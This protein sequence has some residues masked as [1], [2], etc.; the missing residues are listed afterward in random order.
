MSYLKRPDLAGLLQD[1]ETQAVQLLVGGALVA[2]RIVI[3]RE[4]ITNVITY[5]AR[6]RALTT[7]GPLLDA[8]GLPV[9][10]AFTW[11]AAADLVDAIGQWL[12]PLEIVKALLGDPLTLVNGEPLVAWS[13]SLRR[14]ASIRTALASAGR[15][16]VMPLNNLL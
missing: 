10:S 14:D 13:D 11:S 12:L 4:P 16:G 3:T 5:A 6:A 8:N 15:T 7:T 9:M 2:L 1:D